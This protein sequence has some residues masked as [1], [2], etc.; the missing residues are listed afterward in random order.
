MTH[1]VLLLTCLFVGADPGR[2]YNFTT[3]ELQFTDVGTLQSSSTNQ[4]VIPII[5]DD[6]AEPCKIIDCGLQGGYQVHGIEPNRVYV[7][8][9]DDDC[10]HMLHLIK[11]AYSLC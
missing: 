5:N 3:G 2:D 10:E 1:F 4:I 7:T 9:R 11:H 6:I 8:L